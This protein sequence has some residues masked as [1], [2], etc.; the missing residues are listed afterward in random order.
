MVRTFQATTQALRYSDVP[1]ASVR[2]MTLGGSC[3][4]SCTAIAQ[5]AAEAYIG[6]VEVGSA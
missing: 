5:A 1:V 2:G 3:R 6:L 4:S